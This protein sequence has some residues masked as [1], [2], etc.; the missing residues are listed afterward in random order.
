MNGVPLPVDAPSVAARAAAPRLPHRARSARRTSSRSWI[1][2]GA[3]P[4]TRSPARARRPLHDRWADGTTGPHR[5]F[6]HLEFAT[7]GAA[8]MLHYAQW[9]AAN[10]PEAIGMYYSAIDASFNVNAAGGGDTDAPQVQE[11]PDPARLVPHRLGRRSHDRVARLARGRR[12]LVLLDELSRSASSVGSAAV[13]A[14][15]RRLARRAAPRRL[16]RRPRR[17]RSASST[18]SPGTGGSGT[19]ARSCRT[20]RRRRNGCRRR[21]PTIR[22]ARSTR[23][24]PSSASSST[25]RSAGCSRAIDAR[26]WSDDVDVIF[27][28]DHGELQGDF[29]LLFKGPYHVDALMRLPLDLAPGTVARA[30]R[31]AVVTRPGRARRPRADVLRDRRPRARPMDAGPRAPGRRRRRRRA[32]LRA[33]A[34]RVG[35]RAVRRRRAPAHDHPRRLG[36]HRVPTRVPCTTAPRA[37]STTSTDDPWQRVNRWD[38]PGV[39][40]AASRISSPTSPTTSRPHTDPDST[41]KLPCRH[42]RMTATS[43]IAAGACGSTRSASRSTP[44]HPL[45]GDATCDV[46]IVG[47]GFTGLWTAYALGR[48]RADRAGADPRSRD[49]RVRSIGS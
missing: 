43:G 16:S 29:G 8:G 37:S 24:T 14:A 39:R 40:G 34:H 3:S 27:T 22:C 4:R 46:A 38:D 23:A 48:C 45:T 9:L 41:S 20:T 28:T 7:H 36:V 15:P 10:H 32:R 26:G 47:G 11:Q 6:E 18:R 17:T 44:Q 19:T 30:S 42:R 13:G 12:R 35:Q 21:S 31:R 33:R 49:V 2:S 5:G 1:R 25:K